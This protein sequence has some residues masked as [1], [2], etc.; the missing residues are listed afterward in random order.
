MSMKL[1]LA[2]AALLALGGCV[3]GPYSSDTGYRQGTAT[4]YY[5]TSPTY[6][7]TY[8]PNGYVAEM[9]PPAPTPYSICTDTPAGC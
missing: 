5:Y 8:T 9:P 4:T 3:A 1:V 2:G 7:Y 6:Y